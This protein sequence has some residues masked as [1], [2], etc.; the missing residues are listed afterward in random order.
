MT[1]HRSRCSILLVSRSGRL[2]LSSPCEYP[3]S[4]YLMARPILRVARSAELGLDVEFK[5]INVVEGENFSPELLKLVR[6][7]TFTAAPL[8]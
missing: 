7:F 3:C 2:S 6:A 5:I 4:P 1:T 8:Y